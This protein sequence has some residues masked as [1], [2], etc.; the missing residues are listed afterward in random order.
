MTRPWL[1]QC[2]Q[3]QDNNSHTGPTD[4][5]SLYSQYSIWCLNNKASLHLR[6][7]NSE[8]LNAFNR[9][10]NI[11]AQTDIWTDRT[12]DR[13]LSQSRDGSIVSNENDNSFIVVIIFVFSTFLGITI[14]YWN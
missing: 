11:N 5:A 2:Q 13:N 12:A 10:V 4:E 6:E 8:L 9:R 7:D 14:F 1:H 3:A